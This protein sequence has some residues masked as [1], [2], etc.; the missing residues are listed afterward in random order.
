MSLKDVVAPQTA[1]EISKELRQA[2]KGMHSQERWE[3]EQRE[4][5]VKLQEKILAEKRIQAAQPSLPASVTTISL[6]EF[7]TREVAA[8]FSAELN[9]RRG[10]INDLVATY[11]T[12]KKAKEKP[13]IP[14]IDD[15]D[16]LPDAQI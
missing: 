3:L 4:N 13:F 2:V 10:I 15:W 1:S 12:A 14:K 16:L 8:R 6:N 5:Q 7:L 9:V 11:E